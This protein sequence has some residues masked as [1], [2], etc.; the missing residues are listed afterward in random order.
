MMLSNFIKDKVDFIKNIQKAQM[1]SLSMQNRQS[2]QVTTGLVPF[3]SSLILNKV[4]SQNEHF[5]NATSS[6]E[7]NN[8]SQ[9]N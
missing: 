8:T 5:L 7:T 9:F 2:G 3:N 1:K 6:L 4:K